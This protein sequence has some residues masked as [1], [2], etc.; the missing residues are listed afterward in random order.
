MNEN[1][2]YTYFRDKYVKYRVYIKKNETRNYISEE[3]KHN[4]LI[5]E[6]HKRH[7]NI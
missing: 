4:D 3:I 6:K 2:T 1:I 5:S 7:V